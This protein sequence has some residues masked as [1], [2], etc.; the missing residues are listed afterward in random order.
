MKKYQYYIVKY[1][2]DLTVAKKY[3]YS[4]EGGMIEGSEWLVTGS[5]Y[6]LDENCFDEI[7]TEINKEDLIELVNF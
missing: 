4:C 2:N 7:V 3:S 5:D 6:V 1:K